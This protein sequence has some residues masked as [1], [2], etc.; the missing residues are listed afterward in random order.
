MFI[1][2]VVHDMACTHEQVARDAVESRVC[3]HIYC[4]RCLQQALGHQKKCPICREALDADD[5]QVRLL[6]LLY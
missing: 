3:G 4:E 6:A 5:V 1:L 2:C